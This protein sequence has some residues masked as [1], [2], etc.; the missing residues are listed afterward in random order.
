MPNA[1][2]RTPITPI[3]KLFIR[4]VIGIADRKMIARCHHVPLY[5]AAHR[6]PKLISGN[7]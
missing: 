4:I 5:S 1:L 2:T 6:K 7:K 3:R